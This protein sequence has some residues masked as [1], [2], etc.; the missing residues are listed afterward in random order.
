MREPAFELRLDMD[1]LEAPFTLNNEKTRSRE[2]TLM[3]LD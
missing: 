2:A 3:T 1:R